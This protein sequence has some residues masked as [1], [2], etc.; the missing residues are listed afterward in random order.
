M[1]SDGVRA[2]L[3]HR[4]ARG[5]ARDLPRAADRLR[6]RRRRRSTSATCSRRR[7]R[8]RAGRE[9]LPPG[10]DRDSRTQALS[11]RAGHRGAPMNESDIAALDWQKGDG[12]L[13]AIVQHADTGA[14]LMLGY[15]NPRRSPRRCAS[16]RVTFF[17]RT[18]QRLWD[19]GRDLRQHSSTVEARRRRL[20][21]RHAA[22]HRPA[23]GARCATPAPPTASRG[24][25]RRSPPS[26]RFCAD[27]RA[28]IASAHRRP[29]GGQL[30]GA[31]CRPRDRA[32]WRRR[33]A[34]KDSRWR[35]PRSA[36]TT[37]RWSARAPTSS[38]TCCCC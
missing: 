31:S 13:P 21:P 20:R 32:G 35:W 18:R 24:G 10:D 38:F 16:R 1:A 26:S 3:R 2:R 19:E 37:R 25:R 34:R 28:I 7:R 14:V 22:G 33:S 36:G 11:R 29:A 27:S 17:S 5:R 8:R 4:P 23:R 12:L 6:R 30:H 15:M 9:R